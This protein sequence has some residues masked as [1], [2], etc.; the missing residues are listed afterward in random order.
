VSSVGLTLKK[1]AVSVS[2]A[3]SPSRRVALVRFFLAA[4]AG[5]DWVVAARLVFS[6]WPRSWSCCDLPELEEGALG[7]DELDAVL[8]W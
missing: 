8:A 6:G 4:R 5:R 2:E 7:A 1:G 3:A